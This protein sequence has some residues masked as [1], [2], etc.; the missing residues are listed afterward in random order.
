[1]LQSGPSV[2]ETSLGR[3]ENFNFRSVGPPEGLEGL[4][5]GAI[6]TNP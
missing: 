6:T 5:R 2:G 4:L 1:M 3:V